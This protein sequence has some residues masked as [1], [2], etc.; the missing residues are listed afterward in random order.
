MGYVAFQY[1]E[2]LFGMALED[3][4]I[5][6]VETAYQAFVEAQDE[7]I[8]KFLNHPKVTKKDKKDIVGK[9][10]NDSLF[11]HF[12]FV[13][14]DNSRIEYLEECLEEY[15]KIVD[16]QNKVMNV[17]VYSMKALTSLEFNRL[18]DNL[19]KKHNRTVKLENIVDINIVGGLRIEYDGMILDETINHY[20]GSLKANLVK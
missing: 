2:A 8:Y 10:I 9:A 11:R 13:L 14:I 17:S 15:K 6:E 4:K 18:R 7:E 5:N 3:R 20:L 12:V 1:A 19:E 16:N